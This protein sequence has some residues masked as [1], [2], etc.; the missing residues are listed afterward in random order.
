MLHHEVGQAVL[1]GAAVDQPGD[2][3]VIQLRQDLALLPEA[4]HY[5]RRVPV[6]SDQLDGDPLSVLLVVPLGQV[7]GAHA[8]VADLAQD[9]VGADAAT[10]HRLGPGLRQREGPHAGLQKLVRR[11]VGSEQ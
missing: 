6:A 9:P 3:R 4:A 10:P 8:A 5:G 11:G 2:I 1:R 7:D